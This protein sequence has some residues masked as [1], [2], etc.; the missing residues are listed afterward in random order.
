MKGSDIMKLENNFTREEKLLY[1]ILEELRKLNNIPI[2]V[3]CKYCGGIHSNKGSEL[4]CAK[5]HKN[6]GV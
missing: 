1:Q 2:D 3:K 4:A 6:G 5:K